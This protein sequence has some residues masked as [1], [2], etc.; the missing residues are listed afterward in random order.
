MSDPYR[1]GGEVLGERLVVLRDQR[2]A[3]VARQRTLE[4]ELGEVDR[5]IASTCAI[6]ARGSEAE[7]RLPRLCRVVAVLLAVGMVGVVV[8]SVLAR[9]SCRKP[10]SMVAQSGAWSIRQAAELYLNMD[11]DT[12]ACPDLDDL[13]TA[14]KVDRLKT[15]DPWGTPYRIECM[16]DE[17]T[18]WSAGR[19]GVF[20]TADDIADDFGN[21]DFRRVAELD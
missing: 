9:P 7:G 16:A 11:A 1:D 4:G 12:L 20:R 3:I 18:V 21:M 8:A 13:V 19:D 14:R 10:R 6:A 5:D 2:A 17:M 15:D